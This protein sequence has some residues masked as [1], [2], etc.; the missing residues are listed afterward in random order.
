MIYFLPCLLALLFF[1]QNASDS[2]KLE[3]MLRESSAAAEKSQGEAIRLND[4][5][6]HITTES[7]AR[8]L[9]NAVAKMFADQLPP[10]WATRSARRRVARAEYHAVTDPEQLISEDRL[11]SIWN[12]YARAIGTS[13]EAIV[14]ATEVH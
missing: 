13:N 7:D 8:V 2:Q 4:I 12:E 6:G 14:T 11:A 10:P 3:R 1:Q 5:A 9:V